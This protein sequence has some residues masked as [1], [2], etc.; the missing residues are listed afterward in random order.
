MTY[1]LDVNR[2]KSSRYV[3]KKDD[4]PSR[5]IMSLLKSRRYVAKK[6]PDLLDFEKSRNRV[7]IFDLLCRFFN[8]VDMWRKKRHTFSMSYVAF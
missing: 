3:A 6:T 1:L 7:V 4:I 5:C 2:V 8:R